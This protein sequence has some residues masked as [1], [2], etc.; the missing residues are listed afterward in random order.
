MK[1]FEIILMNRK[2]IS[3]A[4]LKAIDPIEAEFGVKIWI[5][6]HLVALEG[7]YGPYNMVKIYFQHKPVELYTKR[8]LLT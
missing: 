1:I 2:L 5:R 4:V 8:K 3:R 7:V 6:H